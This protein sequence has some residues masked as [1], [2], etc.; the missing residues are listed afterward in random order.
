MGEAMWYLLKVRFISFQTEMIL[1]GIKH[2]K[3]NNQLM[4]KVLCEPR[5]NANNQ[6]TLTGVQSFVPINPRDLCSEAAVI[7]ARLRP[8][9]QQKIF[10][11]I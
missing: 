11:D 6:L 4:S 2:R 3:L 10:Q 1:T 7:A 8:R 9:M 5:G